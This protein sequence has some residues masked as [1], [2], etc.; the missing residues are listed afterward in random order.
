MVDDDR[1]PPPHV[2][3]RFEPAPEPVDPTSRVPGF[4][5]AAARRDAPL[6]EAGRRGRPTPAEPIPE[7]PLLDPERRGR[8]PRKTTVVLMVI[9][10]VSLGVAAYVFLP[11]GDGVDPEE[12][13]LQDL[14][15]YGL[16]SQFP[17]DRAALASAR[18]LCRDL[19]DGAERSGFQRDL[20]A[21]QDLCPRFEKGFEVRQTPTQMATA[22]ATRLDSAGLGDAYASNAAA[23]RRAKGLCAELEAGQRQRGTA[24]DKVGVEVYCP[25]Q[26]FRFAEY[27]TTTALGSFTLH[28]TKIDLA[29]PPITVEGTLCNGANQF[30]DYHLGTKVTVTD[31]QGEPL[32][33]TRLRSGRGGTTQCVFTFTV[34]LTEG[35]DAYVFTV[36]DQAPQSYTF[37]Q[38]LK[39]KVRIQADG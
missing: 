7:H 9:L 27:R 32:G 19:E 14:H 31:G 3:P 15:A 8:K 5:G 28:P 29:K 11:H 12:E 36:G 23:V 17:S 4:A 34:E 35:E 33:V 24:A 13:Y 38:I 20:V 22:L 37:E 25:D 2:G 30:A 16:A 6:S 26:L 10:L 21:V 1:T 18:R 39:G